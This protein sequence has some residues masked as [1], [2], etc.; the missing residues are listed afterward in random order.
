MFEKFLLNRSL[1]RILIWLAQHEGEYSASIIQ[2][3]LNIDNFTFVKYLHLLHTMG[4]CKVTPDAEMEDL[5][6]ET[7][8]DS[9]LITTLNDINDFINEQMNES[10]EIEVALKEGSL[11]DLAN[12]KSE[13]DL[14]EL[15]SKSKEEIGKDELEEK[16]IDITEEDML[17]FIMLLKCFM[18]VE[19]E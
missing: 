17:K 19:E 5:Y 9:F 7:K 14:N 16:N 11:T 2:E 3:E 4:A 15:V 6:V 1:M 8:P 13:I 12:E 18:N 10:I